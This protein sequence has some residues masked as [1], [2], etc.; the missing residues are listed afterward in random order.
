MLGL[1]DIIPELE[2][3]VDGQPLTDTDATAVLNNNFPSAVVS[4]NH[5]LG[6]LHQELR[7]QHMSPCKLNMLTAAEIPW[8]LENLD[9]QKPAK[10]DEI[11]P[12]VLKMF[13]Q[14]L[15]IPVVIMFNTCIV[16]G[17]FCA[18]FKTALIVPVPKIPKPEK[19]G[20]WRPVS[21]LLVL[22]NVF[23]KLIYYQLRTYRAQHDLISKKQF[24]FRKG[25]SCESNL[26]IALKYVR[27]ALDKGLRVA[28]VYPHLAKAFDSV[29]LCLSIQQLPKLGIQRKELELFCSYLSLSSQS[30]WYRKTVSGEAYVVFGFP[31]G[32]KHGPLLLHYLSMTFW[33]C[34]SAPVSH[35]M[36]AIRNCSSTYD[37]VKTVME[38][39]LCSVDHFFLIGNW[40]RQKALWCFSIRPLKSR[41]SPLSNSSS[42]KNPSLP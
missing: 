37:E 33:D 35:A 38:G 29:D 6:I 32:S 14:H 15:S 5:K 27:R 3:L 2:V 24:G 1:K 25:Y 13:A 7:T 31:Q 42:T 12:S 41:N 34:L 36:R 26:I 19:L 40:M 18:E 23:N 20:D 4:I 21:L 30:T 9:M 28:G 16:Q 17:E 11:R 8:K 10:K 22:S 39:D